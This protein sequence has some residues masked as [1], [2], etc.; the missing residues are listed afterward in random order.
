MAITPPTEEKSPVLIAFGR[1][2]RHLRK[3][4][5]FSQEAFADECGIDRSYMGGVERGERN[6]A[7]INIVKIITGLGMRPSEFF[8]ALDTAQEQPPGA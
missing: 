3:A 1:T 4:Q 8:Q 5:G 7:L 2:V 6:I